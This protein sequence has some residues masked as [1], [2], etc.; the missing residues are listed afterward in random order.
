MCA[1]MHSCACETLC[2]YSV[3]ESVWLLA[4]CLVYHV[5]VDVSQHMWE[6]SAL[7]DVWSV[8]VCCGGVRMCVCEECDGIS[9]PMCVLLLL[10][11]C[12]P[13]VVAVCVCVSVLECVC[14]RD[15]VWTVCVL[16]CC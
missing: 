9:V 11:V 15:R 16:C 13:V 6:H 8:C 1:C 5:S 14:E 3:W 7:R 2:V 12:I 10:Y 4:L